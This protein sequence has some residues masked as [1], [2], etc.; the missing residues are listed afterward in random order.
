MLYFYDKGRVVVC[1]NGVLKKSNKT[2]DDL[3]DA[4]VRIRREYLDAVKSN[5]LEIV[6][7]PGDKPDRDQTCH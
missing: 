7:W 4:A 3:I 6:D 2:P 1:V 5:S